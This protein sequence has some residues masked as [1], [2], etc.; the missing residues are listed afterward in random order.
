MLIFQSK[1]RRR[2]HRHSRRRSPFPI[3]PRL[4]KSDE[5][6]KYQSVKRKSTLKNNILHIKKKTGYVPSGLTF[7]YFS[8]HFLKEI[9]ARGSNANITFLDV[10]TFV[11]LSK[12]RISNSFYFFLVWQHIEKSNQIQL[13]N[14]YK[15]NYEPYRSLI[16]EIYLFIFLF[17]QFIHRES[18]YIL[19]L[20]VI[21]HPKTD[22][23]P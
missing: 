17:V 15:V 20:P 9:Y 8:P 14:I 19:I 11:C 2:R 21:N 7:T 13:L 4:K 22:I 10:F 16:S 12:P 6:G 23:N 1:K 3:F 18:I 5:V